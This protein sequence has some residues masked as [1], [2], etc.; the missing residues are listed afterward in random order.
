MSNINKM[1]SSIFQ[2]KRKNEIVANG[3][4][5]PNGKCVVSWLG[6]FQSVVLWDSVKDMLS[7]NGH[8]DTEFNFIK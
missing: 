3:C 1:E 8:S 6:K 7:V 4:V 5:F 2:L